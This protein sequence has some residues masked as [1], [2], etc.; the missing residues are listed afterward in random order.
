MCVKEHAYN[1]YVGQRNAYDRLAS[2]VQLSSN[3][4]L[5]SPRDSRSGSLPRSAIHSP[6]QPISDLPSLPDADE[7]NYPN[8]KF[9]R[10]NQ[11][12]EFSDQAKGATDPTKDNITVRGRTAVAQGENISTL[13]IEDENGEPVD[14]ERLTAIRKLARSIWTK[15][16]DL[17]QAPKTWG[18]ANLSLINEYRMELRRQFPEFRFCENHWKADLLATEN[19]P[20]WHQNHCRRL[21]AEG[22]KKRAPNQS[23]DMGS[24]V[25][26]K[27]KVDPTPE[28]VELA[29]SGTSKSAGTDGETISGSGGASSGDR[30]ISSF[31]VTN[32]HKDLSTEPSTLSFKVCSSSLSQPCQH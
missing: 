1:C 20:S 31:V 17:G 32:L 18:R 14:G 11:W 2:S 28:D 10:R 21:K 29:P 7:A 27:Q 30:G 5:S 24:Q 22:A 12:R 3:I 9:W 8:V 26:K 6:F 16:A 25:P 13:Y 4:R 23:M 15:F 19:Y